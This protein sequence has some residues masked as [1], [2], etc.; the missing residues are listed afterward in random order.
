[1]RDWLMRL[2]GKRGTRDERREEV[3]SV[4]RA[5]ATVKAEAD[6]VVAEFRKT[7]AAIRGR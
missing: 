2:L 3:R 4:Q 1:M 6:R 7:E 5:S